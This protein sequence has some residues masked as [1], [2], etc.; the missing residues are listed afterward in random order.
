MSDRT[1]RRC[2]CSTRH[3]RAIRVTRGEQITFGWLGTCGNRNIVATW[4]E[5]CGAVEV[6]FRWHF[7][8]ARVADEDEG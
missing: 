1:K 3:R 7:P 4:C 8:I 2:G 5:R 6:N